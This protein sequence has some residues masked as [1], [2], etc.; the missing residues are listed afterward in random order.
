M[1][2]L[3]GL[4]PRLPHPRRNSGDVG[5][6]RGIPASGRRQLTQL[7][8]RRAMP[9]FDVLNERAQ[10]ALTNIPLLCLFGGKAY[11]K[12][13]DDWQQ[14]C[15]VRASREEDRSNHGSSIYR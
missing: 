2:A 9:S 12:R 14:R 13:G 8:N 7:K 11:L 3:P 4:R 5:N 10:A 6:A 1:V 15:V